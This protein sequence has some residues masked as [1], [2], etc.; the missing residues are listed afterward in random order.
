[1][2]FT[3]PTLIYISISKKQQRRKKSSHDIL[4]EED[5]EERFKFVHDINYKVSKG[6][7]HNFSEIV[8]HQIIETIEFVLGSIS[9][10]ASYLRL[11]ALSLAHSQLSKVFLTKI[12]K[13]QIEDG[14]FI[15]VFLD[16][17]YKIRFSLLSSFLPM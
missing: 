4:V 17:P 2:L 6:E 14:N 1:M 11:W 5:D 13:A 3:K 15:T 8:T 7:N 12:M 9:N 10:T 16:F